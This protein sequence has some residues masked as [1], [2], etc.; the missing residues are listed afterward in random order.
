MVGDYLWKGW[1]ARGSRRLAGPPHPAWRAHTQ[2]EHDADCI[3][4][5]EQINSDV[6]YDVDV[7]ETT[8]D[9]TSE[10]GRA[11]TRPEPCNEPAGAIYPSSKR[12]TR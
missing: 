1:D 9:Q 3:V 2:G 10:Q 12:G 11:C 5:L 8:E 6:T 4:E 7:E